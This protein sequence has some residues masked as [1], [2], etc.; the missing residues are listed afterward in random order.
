M[1]FKIVLFVCYS[2][3]VIKLSKMNGFNIDII[4]LGDKK[5]NKKLCQFDKCVKRPTFGYEL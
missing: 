4:F 5:K 1:I 2:T 3:F